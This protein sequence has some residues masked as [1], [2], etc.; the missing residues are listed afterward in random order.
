MVSLLRQ[1]LTKTDLV[2][3]YGAFVC[4]ILFKVITNCFA[5][6]VIYCF[7]ERNVSPACTDEAT[8]T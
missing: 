4:N 1:R 7:P 6:K 8:T 5:R 3:S 2:F